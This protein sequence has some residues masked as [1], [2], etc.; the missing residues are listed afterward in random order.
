MNPRLI[1]QLSQVGGTLGLCHRGWGANRSWQPMVWHPFPAVPPIFVH[2]NQR[3]PEKFTMER[4]W[5][6][7]KANYIY[8]YVYNN[9]HNNNQNNNK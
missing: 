1:E 3:T 4:L 2:K 7:V 6:F 9:N 5:G 8:M